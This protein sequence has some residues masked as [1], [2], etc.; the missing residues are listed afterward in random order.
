MNLKRSTILTIFL[1][2]VAAVSTMAQGASKEVSDTVMVLPFENTSGRPE[3]NW[4]GESFADSLSD[5]LRIPR[6]NVLSNE[7]RKIIQQKLRISLSSIPSLAA[8]LKMAQSGKANLLVSGKYSIVQVEGDAAVAIEV[9]AK[10]IRVSEGRFLSEDL[11]GKRI[12][13][14][15]V[16]TDA[17]KNLQTI[18]GQ[19]AY[20]ILYQR[21][22]QGLPYAQTYFTDK[23]VKVPALAFEAYVKGL[24]AGDAEAQSREGYFKNAFR[25]YFEQTSGGVYD[26]AAIELG[27]LYLSQRKF[28][29]ALYYFSRIGSDS[30]N[31][32]EA[33]FYSGLIN[34]RLANFEQALAVLRPLA[35]DRKLAPV[36]NT[37]GAI[38]V[39][40]SRLERKKDMARSTALLDEGL[41][42][43]QDAVKFS[44]DNADALFNYGLALFTAGKYESAI[45]QLKASLQVRE[46]DGECRFLIA[47]ALESMQDP[48]AAEADDEAKRL[49]TEDNRYAKFQAEW[50][51]TKSTDLFNFRVLLPPRKDFVGLVMTK[52]NAAP[53]QSRVDETEALLS[54]AR[55]YSKMAKDDEAMDVLRRVLAGEPMSAEAHY[56]IGMIYFR[57]GDLDE[58]LR[59]L[60]TSLFWDNRFFEAYV[61]LVKIYIQRGD[62][63]L[64]RN[65]FESAKEVAPQRDEVKSLQR[66]LER[67]SK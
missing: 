45:E 43:L 47:K 13:R 34:W 32:A 54:K 28:S 4:V 22:R 30:E 16:I 61:P 65:S 60:R 56:L 11:G 23:A 40:A 44:P 37:L 8:S 17:L 27:H 7:E 52:K 51:R 6:V 48:S 57:R 24:V 25:I 53:E 12:T 55:E 3:F 66:Q 35:D 46:R 5:L 33:A 18:Q 42:Y 21:D 49:L 2:A 1:T 15:I 9:T 59:N 38:A 64:A 10:I 14:D 58:A 36:Y 31:Y 67:C 50:S 41:R 62:C 39:H 63:L 20:Q 29:D 26:V 19:V